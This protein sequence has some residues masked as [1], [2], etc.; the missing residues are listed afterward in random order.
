MKNSAHDNAKPYKCELCNQSFAAKR[1][2]NIHKSKAHKKSE[3]IPN[4]K[5][6]CPYCETYFFNQYKLARHQF[7]KHG[8]RRKKEFICEFEGCN[9]VYSAKQNLD[10]HVQIVHTEGSQ[11]KCEYCGKLF[12]YSFGNLVMQFLPLGRQQNA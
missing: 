3:K 6:Q 10:V 5:T 9:K 7:L 2:L 8:I 1:T 11:Q 12:R 4:K